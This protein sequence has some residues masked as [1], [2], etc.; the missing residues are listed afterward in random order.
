[1]RTIDKAYNSIEAL[2]IL[3]T[4]YATFCYALSFSISYDNYIYDLCK[5]NFDCSGVVLLVFWIMA[6][7]NNWGIWSKSC[8]IFLS[9]L[10]LA[11]NVYLVKN[12]LHAYDT[13]FVCAAYIMAILFWRNEMNTN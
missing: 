11:D 5:A 10:I 6:L 13:I 12:D 1:M 3:W 9:I 2:P 7:K 4:V 8:L